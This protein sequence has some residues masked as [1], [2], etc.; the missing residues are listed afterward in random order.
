[1]NSSEPDVFVWP[2][3]TSNEFNV[4]LSNNDNYTVQIFST[5]GQ[6]LREQ[7]NCRYQTAFNVST[8]P[9][10]VYIINVY[11]SNIRKSVKF[12]KE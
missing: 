4:A 5:M 2:T 10:G 6:L 1:V 11:N 7:T 9:R 3:I 12:I 8:M